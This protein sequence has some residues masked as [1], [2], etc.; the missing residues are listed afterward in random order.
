[1]NKYIVTSLALDKTETF[2][3]FEPLY[4]S[5][6]FHVEHILLIDLAICT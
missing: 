4:S 3:G 5:L 1:M 2:F 6:L